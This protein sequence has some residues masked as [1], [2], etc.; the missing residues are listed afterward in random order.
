MTIWSKLYKLYLLGKVRVSKF[1]PSRYAPGAAAFLTSCA[2]A[3]YLLYKNPS[4]VS[5]SGL[6]IGKDQAQGI[7]KR[8][9]LESRDVPTVLKIANERQS[10]REKFNFINNVVK[11][12]APAVLY[13]II[14]DPSQV[15]FDTKSPVITSTGSGFIINEDGWALTNAHVVLEQPQSIINVITYDGLA[16]TASLEHVD[17]SKDLALIKINA[18]KKLPV[19]EFGSSKD[20]IVGEWVVALGSPLSLTNSV[21]VGIVSSIN[22]SAEDIG[23]RN[24]PMTYIQ[25]DASITFGNSGGPLVNLDGHV[26]GINNLRLTAGICFAIPVDYAKTFLDNAHFDRKIK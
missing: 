16:Y 22:R 6:L 23:L 9:E 17:V 15:D 12:C 19:L 20:A 8:W 25:T 18:D 24:Y 5:P 10:N 1:A 4:G 21:S 2:I 7:K 14:S 3:S 11:K 26:I 13:I